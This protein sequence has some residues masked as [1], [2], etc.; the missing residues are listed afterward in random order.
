MRYMANQP[1]TFCH[2]LDNFHP[3]NKKCPE[4]TPHKLVICGFIH[5]RVQEVGVGGGELYPHLC[6][7]FCLLSLPST[8]TRNHTGTVSELSAEARQ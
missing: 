4:L 2:G 6:F 5:E 7:A 1:Q 8:V 3:L